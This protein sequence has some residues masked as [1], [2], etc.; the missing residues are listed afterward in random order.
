MK[1]V[2]IGSSGQLGK[3]LMQEF[4]EAIGLNHSEI[5][6]TDYKSVEE[7][8]LDL[9]PDVVINAAAYVKVDDAEEEAEKAFAVNALGA[10]NVAKACEKIGAVNVYISTDYVFDGTKG[11][12]YSEEDKP[13]PINV[14]G[15]SK[16]TGEFFTKNYSKKHYVIRVASLYGGEGTKSKGNFVLSIL[17]K[18]ASEK[19]LKVVNDVIVSPT[20]TDDAAKMIRKILENNLD[21]GIYHAVNEGY[22]SWFDFAKKIIEFKNLDVDI[23]PVSSTVFNSKARRP[24]FSA[25]QNKKLEE[26]GLSMRKWQEALKDYLSSI[27][28]N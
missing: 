21:Y 5:E 23:K 14:Y 7:K 1:V 19:E 10:L 3:S 18:A 25:L 28:I 4:K 27:P 17:K 26:N 20:Y 16:L 11:Q 13:N 6:V 2:V 9:K 12:A 15:S 8:L 22:C 24:A